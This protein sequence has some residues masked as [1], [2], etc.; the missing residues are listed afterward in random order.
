M[1]N[2]A[3]VTG[4]VSIFFLLSIGDVIAQQQEE[5]DKAFLRIIYIFDQQADKEKEQIVVTDTM[6]LD[7]GQHWS[8]YYDW[9]KERRDSIAQIEDK[10]TLSMIK[11]VNVLKDNN[12]ILERFENRNIKPTFINDR[13]GESAR[14]F[15]N[16]IQN[17]IVTIDIGPGYGEKRSYLRLKEEIPPMDWQISEDT[18]S[19]MGYVCYKATTSFRGRDYSV[20]F[21]PEVPVNDGPW[22]LY[23]LPGAIL[24]AKTE[25]GLFRF[26][27]IG[28]E[29]L[30]D[31]P[32]GFPTDR[33]FE[34]AKNL[35][36]LN[37]YRRSKLKDLSISYMEG[38]NMTV[39]KKK[40]PV[41]YHDLELND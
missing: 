40:N 19:V 8:V 1:G 35:K 13:K 10:K 14:I 24:S 17:E 30:R 6:A 2:K 25:D 16:R 18:L 26:H 15:K 23:G 4:C 29:Q 7:I 11:S 5:L 27:A 12:E 31:Q 9:N 39:F 32:I 41:S 20:W 33:I 3:I 38:S 36:Q 22:K 21:S 37:E 28:L 34:E